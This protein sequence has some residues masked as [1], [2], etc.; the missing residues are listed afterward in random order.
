MGQSGAKS[1]RSAAL[2]DQTLAKLARAG[3]GFA[4]DAG[5]TLFRQGAVADAAYLVSKGRLEVSTRIPGDEIA[6]VSAIG[7]G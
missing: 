7:P 3:E 5:E 4:L 6:T 2:D 1:N